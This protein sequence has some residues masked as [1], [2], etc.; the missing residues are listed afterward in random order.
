MKKIMVIFGTR[1]EAIKMCPLILELK[2]RKELS[3]LICLTGQHKQMLK[4]VM[5]A[6]HLKEDF[7]LEIMRDKQTLTTITSDILMGLE[8][9]IKSVEPDLILVHGDTTTSFAAALAAFYQKVPVGHVEAGLRTGNKYS[10]YPEEMN[11]VLISKIASYHFAPT[12]QNQNN[13]KQEGIFDNV[14]VTGNT[15]IDAFKTTVKENYK[16]HCDKLNEIDFKNR[17]IILVTAHRRENWGIPLTN[18]C[19]AIEKIANLYNNV[20]IIYPVHFNPLVRETV[21]PILEKKK[22]ILLI[23][24]IDV[25]DMHNLM[26]KC[27]MVMTDSGG[28]Q[29]EAPAFGKPVLVLRTETERPEAVQAGTVE[30]VGIEEEKIVERANRLLDSN[31]EYLKMAHSV[32][33]YGDGLASKRIADI[34]S[35]H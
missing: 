5:N 14:F 9:I 3:V 33:P 12:V 16:F 21:Y 20:E 31:E 1:P 6:F 29:E 4:Q 27:Y 32:N 35:I 15:V 13:L 34:I 8:D 25:L 11:R 26:S 28:I 10:P 24:P 17:R 30:V 7:N 19:K 23:D 22:N 18:I 2:K